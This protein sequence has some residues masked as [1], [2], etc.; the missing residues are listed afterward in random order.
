MKNFKVLLLSLLLGVS[1]AFASFTV[2]NSGGNGVAA[3]SVTVT[4]SIAAG[5][6]VVACIQDAAGVST[7]GAVTDTS[8]GANAYTTGNTTD[9]FG[10]WATGCKWSIAIPSSITSVTYTTAGTPGDLHMCVWDITATDTITA[11]DSDTSSGFANSTT[12]TDGMASP[13]LTIAG[14]DGLILTNI[15]D[16]TGSTVTAGTGFTLDVAVANNDKCAHRAIS[17]SAPATWTNSAAGS[18]WTS[19]AVALEVAPPPAASPSKSFLTM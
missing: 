8:G 11:A 9:V 12:A 14:A 17:A 10:N 7:L 19:G 6:T 2:V 5:H 16:R 1:P 15:V 13:T 18:S 4:I 3:G